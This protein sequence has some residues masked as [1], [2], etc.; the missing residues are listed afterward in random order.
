M[1]LQYY[2]KNL[3]MLTAP[4]NVMTVTELWAYNLYWFYLPYD[5]AEFFDDYLFYLSQLLQIIEYFSSPY[6]YNCGYCNA[7]V[8]FTF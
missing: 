2:G 1:V 4:L 3:S 8:F 6:A 5:C 7:N